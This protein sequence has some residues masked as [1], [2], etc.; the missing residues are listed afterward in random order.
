MQDEL[1]KILYSFL[2]SDPLLY[3]EIETNGFNPLVIDNYPVYKILPLIKQDLNYVI[4]LGEKLFIRDFLELA[5]TKPGNH[6]VIEQIDSLLRYLRFLSEQPGVVNLTDR[7]IEK[8]TSNLSL[9]NIPFGKFFETV[10]VVEKNYTA[11]SLIKDESE[12]FLD[13]KETGYLEILNFL[14]PQDRGYD[15]A[16]KFVKKYLNKHLHYKTVSLDFYLKHTK[17][18]IKILKVLNRL[19][20]LIEISVVYRLWSRVRI[21]PSELYSEVTA[22]GDLN[23]L[24]NKNKSFYQKL[25]K[26][27][28]LDLA[29]YYLNNPEIVK[30]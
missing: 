4:Y 17:D 14:Y 18:M 3:K 7:K 30:F 12:T 25:V 9:A 19:E 16:L 8:L 15:A 6:F 20:E 11:L 29:E 13:L 26:A 24:K 5:K 21:T 27:D 2:N 1:N 10:L 22:A 28:A 23:T